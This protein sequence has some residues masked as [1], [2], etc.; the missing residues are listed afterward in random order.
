M[1]QDN[2]GDIIEELSINVRTAWYYG[3]LIDAYSLE[4][5]RLPHVTV[6]DATSEDLNQEQISRIPSVIHL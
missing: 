5:N 4:E 3:T 6:F 1:E 2:E